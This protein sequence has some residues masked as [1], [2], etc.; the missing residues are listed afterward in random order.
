MER[1]LMLVVAS[2]ARIKLTIVVSGVE[3]GVRV[4]DSGLMVLEWGLVE[5]SLDA[6]SANDRHIM[7]EM[8]LIHFVVMLMNDRSV[9]SKIVTVAA[10]VMRL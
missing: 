8:V 4:V 1:L 3:V 10:D 7:A 6:R 2:Q 9:S 5:D